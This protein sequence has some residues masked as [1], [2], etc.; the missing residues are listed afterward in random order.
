MYYWF[1]WS[2]SA[3]LIHICS[4]RCFYDM[5]YHAENLT[6]KIFMC[7]IRNGSNGN[8]VRAVVSSDKIRCMFA[9]FPIRCGLHRFCPALVVGELLVYTTR[10]TERPTES[11][12]FIRFTNSPTAIQ[13]A[14]IFYKNKG[15]KNENTLLQLGA[16]WL[17]QNNRGRC[18]GISKKCFK[19]HNQK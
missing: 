15:S 18:S 4:L 12:D 13:L 10:E 5:H 17:Y 11:I 8:W 2:E 7:R 6:F 19:Q 16:L 3:F 1:L 9:S 14:V